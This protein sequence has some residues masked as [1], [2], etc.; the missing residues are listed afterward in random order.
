MNKNFLMLLLFLISCFDSFSMSL[1]Q[2]IPNSRSSVQSVSFES[3][4]NPQI[5]ELS[6][7]QW[8]AILATGG[9]F[10]LSTL[11]LLVADGSQD[12]VNV[13]G[14]TVWTSIVTS[15]TAWFGF[16]AYKLYKTYKERQLILQRQETV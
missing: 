15:S 12:F 13:S 8:R 7:C 14:I 10:G 6:S 16:T 9:A 1:E 5:E 3:I 11:A 2:R 4:R